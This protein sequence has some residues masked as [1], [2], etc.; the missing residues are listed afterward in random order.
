M[1]ET[2]LKYAGNKRHLMKQINAHFNW[3]GI[4][5]YVEPF[6]GALGSALNADVPG[7]V[8]IEIS[9]VNWELVH[10]YA[11]VRDYPTEVEVLANSWSH[12]ESAYYQ[13][14]DWD[15]EPGWRTLKSPIE[16]AARTLYLNKRGF[17]GLYRV[18]PKTG[19]FNV[20]WNHAK[21]CMPISLTNKIDCLTF[22]KRANVFLSDWKP[23]VQ[24]TTMGD[25][26]YC[27]PPYVIPNRPTA[28]SAVYVNDFG[29]SQQVALRDELLAAR[30]RGV[31]VVATNSWCDTTLE[32]YK[33]FNI[34]ELT[35]QR[36]LSRAG[37][38][39]GA[40]KELLAWA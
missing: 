18:N 25:L 8:S 6:A 31:R 32:L 15:K 40:I 9:D 3:S 12:E 16:I 7:D 28:A 2:L 19:C 17:N 4:I 11:T 1:K 30:N 35:A 24:T 27:D 22:L 20:S 26:L 5:R 39:R 13:I 10:F 23:V 14:R 29:F 21:K 34:V 36:S 33:D 38:T 37:A